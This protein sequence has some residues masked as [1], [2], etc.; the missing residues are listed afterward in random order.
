[1]FLNQ[2]DSKVDTF[3]ISRYQS[4]KSSQSAKI[5]INCLWV[6]SAL[7]FLGLY[8]LSQLPSL[9]APIFNTI[10][11]E[12]GLLEASSVVL[13]FVT[14]LIFLRTAGTNTQN[15]KLNRY[16]VL[17]C[18]LFATL[19]FVVGGEEI[20]WGQRIFNIGT[21]NDLANMNLQGELNFHNIDGIHQHIRVVGVLFIL[22][23]CYFI[24]LSHRNHKG[25]QKIYQQYHFPIFPLNGI[26]PITIAI[27]YMLIP[28]FF[29]SQSVFELDEIGEFYLSIAWVLFAIKHWALYKVTV[30][31]SRFLT[32]LSEVHSD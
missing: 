20:S 30:L 26:V 14:T 15:H 21:P 29:F 19:F 11:R 24:P 6:F 2:Q 22:V 32:S 8:F 9:K 5:K 18:L 23:L 4:I 1:M 31:Q 27:L 16:H 7:I 3:I 12:D 25:L 10:F 17:W 13:Y 28:R